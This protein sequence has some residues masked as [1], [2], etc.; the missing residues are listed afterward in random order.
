LDEAKFKKV[1]LG[2][3]KLNYLETRDLVAPDVDVDVLASNLESIESEDL[4]LALSGVILKAHSYI[5]AK[6]PRQTTRFK[7]EKPSDFTAAEF[8][9]TWKIVSDPMSIIDDLE[10]GCLCT[11]QVAT[12]KAV[13]PNLYEIMKS[14][15]FEAVA[16]KIADDPEYLV[17]YPKLKQL[18][19]LLQET[20]VPEDL[21]SMLQANFKGG[22]EEE[23]AKS[24]KA[25]TGIAKQ[26]ATG[27]EKLQFDIA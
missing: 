22:N 10:M 27:L 7:A 5:R 23:Q 19:I 21:K 13:Y 8:L 20:L 24:G 15:A 6:I 9:R 14:A 11:S 17:P 12:M 4:S 3:N 16:T 18:T 25:P 26:N 2:F 1:D